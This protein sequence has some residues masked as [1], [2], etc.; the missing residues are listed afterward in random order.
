M[1]KWDFCIYLSKGK[2]KHSLYINRGCGLGHIKSLNSKQ[3]NQF[4]SRVLWIFMLDL[5]FLYHLCY[6]LLWLSLTCRRF[7]LV[8][9]GIGE[10]LGNLGQNIWS[11]QELYM[12]D[13]L[14]QE[15]YESKVEQESHVC[16]M[17]ISLAVNKTMGL[18]AIVHT[19]YNLFLI[20]CW[21]IIVVLFRLYGSQLCYVAM[22][23]ILGGLFTLQI[24]KT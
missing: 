23:S 2:E 19:T 18:M 13:I 15:Q 6:I 9:H 5:Y 16:I 12:Q 4:L 22:W 20:T 24:L 11:E 14:Q 7:N 3:M 17:C 1:Y 10:N 21:V 8:V